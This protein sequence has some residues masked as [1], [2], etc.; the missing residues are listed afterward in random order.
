MYDT[1]RDTSIVLH[2][3]LLRPHRIIVFIY[4]ITFYTVAQFSS[5]KS[6]VKLLQEKCN[7]IFM[8]QNVFIKS[9]QI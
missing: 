3:F 4:I 2:Q 9:K 8:T 5:Y 1:T 7:T 6:N